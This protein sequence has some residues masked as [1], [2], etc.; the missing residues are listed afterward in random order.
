MTFRQQEPV[1]S[2]VLHQPAFVFTSRCWR[3][4][5]DQRLIPGGRISL[6][7]RLPRL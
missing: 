4:V 6:R 3:L 2:G 1:V 5:S 7:Q